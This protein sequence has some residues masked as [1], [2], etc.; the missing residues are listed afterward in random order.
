MLVHTI[1]V[2]NGDVS[3]L[4]V[5]PDVVVNLVALTIEDIKCGFIDVTM[6]LRLS[7]RAILLEVEVKSLGNPILWFDI[8][9]R[10]GLWTIYHFNVSCFANARL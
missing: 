1:V 10:V 9:A 3:S 6:L 4:P 8:M 2:H 5:V 7:A